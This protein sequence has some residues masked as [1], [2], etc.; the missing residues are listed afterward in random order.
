MP[1]H[2][3]LGSVVRVMCCREREAGEATARGN[4]ML[5]KQPAPKPRGRPQHGPSVGRAAVHAWHGDP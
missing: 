1:V 3:A 5:G 2:L 4:H